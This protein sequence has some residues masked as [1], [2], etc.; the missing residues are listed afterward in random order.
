M[1]LRVLLFAACLVMLS[2]WFLSCD[3]FRCFEF[4]CFGFVWWW[5]GGCGYWFLA[6][7]DGIVGWCL[8]TGFG[9]L[10]FGFW[11]LIA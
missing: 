10:D 2:W 7:I 11:V 8:L 3:L 5:F 1:L 6:V 9:W 4:G